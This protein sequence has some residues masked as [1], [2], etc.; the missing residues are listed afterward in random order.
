MKS[1]I[2]AKGLKVG[3]AWMVM[4]GTLC[5]PAWTLAAPAMSWSWE[6]PLPSGDALDAVAYGNG[7]SV[8]AGTDGMI[9]RST[10]GTQ[11]SAI[12]GPIGI[13]GTYK[14][15][16]YAGG[17]FI[18]VG[19]D[20]G[21]VS[22][23]SVSN[24]G[25]TWT[26]HA[27]GTGQEIDNV[28]YGNG[29]YLLTGMV[30]AT[31][32]DAITWQVHSLSIAGPSLFPPAYANGVFVIMDSQG[33]F[34]YS[35]DQGATWAKSP[36]SETVGYVAL[37]VSNGSQ[38]LLLGWGGFESGCSSACG[39]L[40]TSSD[41]V[42]WQQQP[43]FSGPRGLSGAFL[44]IS[45]FVG[46]GLNEPSG[47]MQAYT[48]PD[49]LSWT[50][51]ALMSG[52]DQQDFTGINFAHQFIAA[53]S[54]YLMADSDAPMTLQ[55]SANFTTWTDAASATGSRSNLDDVIYAGGQ[56]VA[57][58]Q[59][60]ILR[61]ADGTSWTTAYTMA[62]SESFNAL[63]YGNGTYVA[64]GGGRSQRFGARPHQQRWTA[65]DGRVDRY[66]R[67]NRSRH[68]WGGALRRDGRGVHHLLW[69]SLLPV[70]QPRRQEL[71]RDQPRGGDVE[72]IGSRGIQRSQ[73]RHH[74]GR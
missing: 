34:Y 50:P 2:D 32:T 61:S 13:R 27:F 31:S 44:G 40:V 36:Y 18:A 29:T 63:A 69:L 19:Q 52:E 10:D 70:D 33:G 73:L 67:R 51:G 46:Y 21:G 48:S 39:F 23:V 22:H 62:A 72:W 14:D 7:I 71:E 25:S 15:I 20:A 59:S 4:L 42:N 65:L 49:G 60:A 43:Y 1:R 17:R 37:L 41:G 9:Y 3:I 12:Q 5:M 26:D 56:Y 38:F 6:N 8:A 74:D 64:V 54:R 16:L 66:H 35:Q 11:W 58:G 30:A 24:D 45:G 57:A 55:Q 28:G 68:L 47:M 53:G